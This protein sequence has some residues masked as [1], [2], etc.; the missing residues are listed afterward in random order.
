MRNAVK[1]HWFHK[2]GLCILYTAKTK[3]MQTVTTTFSCDPNLKIT[4]KCGKPLS[5]TNLPAVHHLK[6]VH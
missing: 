6:S 4:I 5:P 1:C 2:G 3:T